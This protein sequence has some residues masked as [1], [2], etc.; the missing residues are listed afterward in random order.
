MRAARE[1]GR[2][3]PDTSN[4][5]FGQPVLPPTTSRLEL[6]DSD[7]ASDRQFRQLLYDFSALGAHLEIARAYL[8]SLA[9]LSSPQ[10]SCAMIIAYY[11]GVMGVSVSDVAKHLH[12]TTA[13]VTSEAG[14]LEKAGLVKK[15][16]N[17]NDG[18]GILLR[19]T[20]LG[21]KRLREIGPQRLKVNDS[22]FGALSMQDFSNLSR[23]TRSLIDDFAATIRMLKS[24]GTERRRGS[25]SG[26]G[27]AGG[28]W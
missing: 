9:G 12:V 7:G 19:L 23:I 22:L 8:A 15:R 18:R 16:P 5:D 24:L 13:F 27:L 10:Y 14:K 11:Q 1:S 28:A 26:S 6:L 4:C 3:T 17:P 2:P 20:R 21:E 25:T